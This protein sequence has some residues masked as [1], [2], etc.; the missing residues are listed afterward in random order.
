[1]LFE[2]LPSALQP[3]LLTLGSSIACLLFLGLVH[4]LYILEPSFVFFRLPE[5]VAPHYKLAD[6]MNVWRSL[7][8][9]CNRMRCQPLLSSYWPTA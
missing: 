6:T 3:S 4:L 5:S 9:D 2:K 1:M 7:A 8:K